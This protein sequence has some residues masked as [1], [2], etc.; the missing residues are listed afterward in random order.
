M[1]AVAIPWRTVCE[2]LAERWLASDGARKPQCPSGHQGP[3]SPCGSE[4]GAGARDDFT[5]M[6]LASELK[7]SR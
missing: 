6:L 4:L 7:W 1:A 2:R 3:R 5:A